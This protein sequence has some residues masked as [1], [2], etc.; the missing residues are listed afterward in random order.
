MAL[1]EHR[2]SIA[3]I[4]W[5][6]LSGAYAAFPLAARVAELADALAVTG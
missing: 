6:E 3:T 2:R 5:D 4:A 1:D